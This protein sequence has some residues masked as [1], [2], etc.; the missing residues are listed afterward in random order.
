MLKFCKVYVSLRT[1]DYRHY[2]GRLTVSWHGTA[3]RCGAFH[4]ATPSLS[5]TITGRQRGNG[6]AVHRHG[7]RVVTGSIV[8]FIYIC[9]LE[10]PKFSGP[11]MDNMRV[12]YSALSRCTQRRRWRRHPVLASAMWLQVDLSQ[13]CH[14]NNISKKVRRRLTSSFQKGVCIDAPAV[15]LPVLSN[16][17]NQ[18]SVRGTHSNPEGKISGVVAGNIG[19]YESGG[20]LADEGVRSDR[21]GAEGRAHGCVHGC[22]GHRGKSRQ[23]LVRR[24]HLAE[25]NGS[26]NAMSRSYPK[27]MCSWNCSGRFGLTGY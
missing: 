5:H 1:L 3:V 14:H 25:V 12:A 7:L 22:E 19:Q 24:R 15:G 11:G 21:T 27:G 10:V 20:C 2:N 4:G 16:G 6:V 8:V 26:S 18:V 13:H 17:L 9:R 23:K